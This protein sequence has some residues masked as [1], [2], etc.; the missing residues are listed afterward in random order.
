VLVAVDLRDPGV[1]RQPGSWVSRGLRTVRSTGLRFDHVPAAAVGPPGWY[2]SRPGFAWG[3]MGVAAVWLG[4][5]AGLARRLRQA[6]LGREPDQVGLALLGQAD[7][8]LVAAAAVL[9]DA[10]R[11]VD[12]GLAAGPDAWPRAVRVRH[13]V[14]DACEAVLSAVAH[15]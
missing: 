7:A 5:A 4:G 8:R 2:L 13:V 15:G 11:A 9:T 12:A 3:G 6:A 1:S 10:A 14:H